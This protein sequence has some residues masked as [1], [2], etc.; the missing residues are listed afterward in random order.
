MPRAIRFHLNE[1]IGSAVAEGA[2]PNSAWGCF[3]YDERKISLSM[4]IR[5]RLRLFNQSSFHRVVM[6][7]LY[8]LLK[9]RHPQTELGV[10]PRRGIIKYR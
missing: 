1:H 4:G 9:L 3:H 10:A 5:P 7:V 8:H 6:N 2:T